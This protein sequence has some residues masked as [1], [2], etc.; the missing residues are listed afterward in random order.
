MRLAVLA[1]LTSS[2]VP[3]IVH[4]DRW[5]T[6]RTGGFE[7][8]SDAGEDVAAEAVRRLSRLRAALEQL[9]PV[10]D[11]SATPI[12]R[13]LVLHSR[14]A[15]DDLVPE[16]RH[17]RVEGFFVGGAEGPQLVVAMPSD[18]GAGASSWR[19]LD[20]EYVHVHLGRALRAQPAWIAE[21][22]AEALSGGSFHDREAFLGQAPPA[23]ARVAT[24]AE[25]LAVHWDSPA[26]R[27]NDTTPA[28]YAGA[29]ALVRLVLARHGLPALLEHVGDVANG[30]DAGDSFRDRYGPAE[31]LS[32]DA[33]LSVPEGPL[34]RV[35]LEPQAAEPILAFV[36]S[37]ADVESLHGEVLLRGGRARAA[38]RRFESALREDPAHAGARS[39]LARVHLQNGRFEH[40]RRELR[41]VLAGRPDD[42][43]ALLR[44]AQLLLAE[45]RSRPEGLTDAVEAEAIGALE[46]AVALAPDLAEAVE[47]LA[48]ERPRPLAHR[49]ALLR[50]AFEADPGRAELGLTLSWLL[51][52]RQDVDGAR[53]VL[54]R[55]RDAARD[56]SYR[57]LCERRLAQLGEYASGTKEAVGRLVKLD[58][59]PDGSLLFTIAT[60]MERLALEASSPRSFF[61]TGDSAER[62]LVCGVQDEPVRARYL[63]SG[64]A[65]RPGVLLSLGTGAGRESV[66]PGP[67]PS[68]TPAVTRRWA[69]ASAAA[70]HP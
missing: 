22:L 9:L 64:E 54:R 48:H 10:E 46:R 7:V 62:E 34:F 67:R 35:P 63:P 30:R 57:F 15:F 47:L 13:V 42:P 12:V 50:R 70:R 68:A 11:G 53:A 25:V 27:G 61:L 19:T 26:Y 39:G 3:A 51:L 38:E 24:A 69:P 33:L 1:V 32:R 18:A 4:A 56:S 49:I 43:L 8:T 65:G 20:H 52:K 44:Q 55:S 58:C 45:G 60:S 41:L 14:G 59:R 17:G 36:P 23:A 21:G 2:L 5:A 31:A 6:A 66:S 40:A 28:F 16:G 29:A 37:T